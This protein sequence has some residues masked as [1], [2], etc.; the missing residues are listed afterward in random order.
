MATL[1]DPTQIPDPS[2]VS[3][4]STV[5]RYGLIGGL[6]FI[7]YGLIANFLGWNQP[8]SSASMLNMVI[9]IALFVG[10]MVIAIR[11]HRDEE[12]AGFIPFGRAFGV[13]FFTGMIATLISS[14]FQFIY[15]KFIDPG[16]I[17]RIKETTL[18]T[19]EQM[20]MTEE[21]I[22]QSMEMLDKMYTPGMMVFWAVIGAAVICA[23]VALI[24]AAVMKRN[25]PT[26]A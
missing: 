14:I 16:F 25:P 8:G 17:D 19:Y 6:V 13:G 22:E 26:E 5:Q 2:E 15:V 12:L 24:V 10:L 20:G 1:D 7:I 4:W 18:E 3:Q 21:R 9:S 11:Q 23:I